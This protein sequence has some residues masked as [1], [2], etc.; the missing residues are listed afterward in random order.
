VT[1]FVIVNSLKVGL[2]TELQELRL[3][4]SSYLEKNTIDWI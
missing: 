1:G 3:F 4:P 2:V